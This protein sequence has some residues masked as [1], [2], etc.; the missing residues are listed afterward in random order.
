MSKMIN[1]E[2]LLNAEETRALLKNL[3]HPSSDQ[4]NKRK[5]F[6]ASA[7]ALEI[8]RQRAETIIEVPE[9]ELFPN[10]M[11]ID[12]TFPVKQVRDNYSSGKASIS[13]KEESETISWEFE[14]CKFSYTENFTISEDF[15]DFRKE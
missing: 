13:T 3:Q 10:A 7:Q 14:P 15:S 8:K 1:D 6:W 5:R 2:L 12:E 9:L 11:S 4:V